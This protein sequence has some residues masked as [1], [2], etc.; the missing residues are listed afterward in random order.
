MVK[1]QNHS[2]NDKSNHEP[3]GRF[4]D[5]SEAWGHGA[6]SAGQNILLTV[7]RF[8]FEQVITSSAISVSR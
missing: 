8:A 6:T 4:Q 1:V 7:T 3:E 2:V 5:S